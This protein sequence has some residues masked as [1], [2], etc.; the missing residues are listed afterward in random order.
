MNPHRSRQH[1][2]AG[3][4]SSTM[5]RKKISWSIKQAHGQSA[6]TFVAGFVVLGAPL[7]AMV[8]AAPSQLPTEPPASVRAIRTGRWS[9]PRSRTP[10]VQRQ[11]T[12]DRF[13]DK[14][15]HPRRRTAAAE[16]GVEGVLV[17]PFGLLLDKGVTLRIG[18]ADIGRP[19][20]SRPA[21]PRAA[22][23]H[24]TGLGGHAGSRIHLSIIEAR[25]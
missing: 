24:W 4:S 9:A 18:E 13:Q 6:Q 7:A 10:T 19:C 21:F 16:D 25:K 11:S 5:T 15:A 3:G 17:M 22:L 23:C 1:H 12:A 2:L 14:P 20:G 8:Q